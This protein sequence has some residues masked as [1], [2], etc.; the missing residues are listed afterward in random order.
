MLLVFLPGACYL[1]L[2]GEDVVVQQLDLLGV[3]FNRY[4]FMFTTMKKCSIS[5]IDSSHHGFR[6]DRLYREKGAVVSCFR[7]LSEAII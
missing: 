3:G 1:L 4:H 5:R 2:E 7:V 6:I